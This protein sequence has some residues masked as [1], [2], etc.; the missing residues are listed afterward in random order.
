MK[1]KNVFK[2]IDPKLTQKRISYRCR[3]N[4][5]F[6]PIR[7]SKQF[8]CRNCRTSTDLYIIRDFRT[9]I[10]KVHDSWDKQRGPTHTYGKILWITIYIAAAV[11]HGS[12]VNFYCLLPTW[13]WCCLINNK[14][15]RART[16]TCTYNLL[17]NEI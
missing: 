1:K 6:S 15:L 14:V 8:A 13:E 9:W 11:L 4:W 7:N 3:S 2:T 12:N 10:K 17:S 5:K 16:N